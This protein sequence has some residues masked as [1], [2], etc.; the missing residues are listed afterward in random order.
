LVALLLFIKIIPFL[1]GGINS[2]GV[3]KEV[4]VT[5]K[6]TKHTGTSIDRPGAAFKHYLQYYPILE[7]KDENG[8][9]HT[10]GPKLFLRTS[11]RPKEGETLEIKYLKSNPS[12]FILLRNNSMK[13][14]IFFAVFV[15]SFCILSFFLLSNQ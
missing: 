1:I 7:Y 2:T 10:D 12:K 4:I 8:N 15:I 6:R 13:K 5:E 3:V 9:A 11:W 14:V